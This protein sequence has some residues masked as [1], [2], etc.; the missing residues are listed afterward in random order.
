MSLVEFRTW[1]QRFAIGLQKAGL[2]PGDRVLLFS[3][4]NLFFPVAFMGILM[5]GGIFTGANPGFVSRELAYQLKD[6]EA[7]FLLCADAA[8][9]IGIEAATSIGM[10]KESIFIFDDELFEGTGPE[11]LGI[12]NWKELVAPL[13]DKTTSF[14]WY[15]P[16]DPK[17][18]T[19]CLNYSSGTTGVPKGVEI[20]HF[21]Y[22]SNATQYKFIATLDPNYEEKNSKAKWICFLPM[23]HAMAQ[24]IF[25][26]VAV[27]RQVPVYIMKKFDFIQ[28]LESVQKFKIT[29]LTMVPPIVV[30][31]AKHPATKKYDLSSIID[32]TSGA[33]PL[34]GDV[35]EEAEALW[36]T[37]DR[38]LQQGWGMT[39]AT[40]AVMGWDPN[41]QNLSGSVGELHANCFAKI[42]D[43]EGKTEVPAGERG[44]IWVQ[45]PN[46]MK[47]YWRNP[48]ATRETLVDD[49]D[50]RWLRTGDIAFINP[51]GY[52][53]IVD[54]I[55]ELIKVKGNQV[56]PAELEGVL[57]EHPGIA[58]ACVVGVTI[59]GEEVPRAYVVPRQGKTPDIKEVESWMAG[60]VSRFKRLV[61]GVVLADGIPKNPSG[62]ILR[63]ILRERAKEEVG[64]RELERAK[65]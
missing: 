28:V 13:D 36:P 37:K 52:F 44:E 3:G 29:A 22:V 34:T 61:G 6:S 35:I 30:A 45:G 2:K 64:D 9:E 62:K 21:N 25:I 14:E 54:R 32:I 4:N 15:E 19:C 38:T 16:S 31:L 46:I 5:A 65:L 27:R 48:G 42:M 50:G 63:K 33:A 7:T 59:N 55:K 20:T 18:M 17:E 8:L 58:D 23:Y 56:A 1:S 40:C 39:E 10:K 51:S 60:R 53:F 47:G 49:R 41:R 24:T 57:L 43:S 11:R 26:S 12:R